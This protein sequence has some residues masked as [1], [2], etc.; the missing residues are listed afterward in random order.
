MALLEG[1]VAIVT[2][3]G[4]G[5]GRAHALAL[6]RHGASAVVNDIGPSV[7]CAGA[8]QKA[9]DLTVELIRERGG[10]A[11][12]SSH[13]IAAHASDGHM[14]TPADAEFGSLTRPGHTPIGIQ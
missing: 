8:D 4:H 14:A 9:A 5:I 11:V 1:K 2:G 7:T 3:A 13:D 10:T 6:A 12:A